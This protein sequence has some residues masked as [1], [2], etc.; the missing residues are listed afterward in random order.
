MVTF[1]SG[2]REIS[3]PRNE[4]I[5][6]SCFDIPIFK[7]GRLGHAVVEDDADVHMLDLVVV[8]VGSGTNLNASDKNVSKLSLVVFS[9]DSSEEF[10]K[11]VVK[12]DVESC[13]PLSVLGVVSD[14]LLWCLEHG[15]CCCAIVGALFCMPIC[16]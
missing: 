6:V 15:K 2:V 5:T 13:I 12:L 9:L 3:V 16:L 10:C 14:L 11:V 4:I 7:N 1:P 8:L